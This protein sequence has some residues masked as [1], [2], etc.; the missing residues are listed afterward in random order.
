MC[1]F[2]V[3]RLS[4][5]T[6]R[7]FFNWFSSSFSPLVYNVMLVKIFFCGG[8]NVTKFDLE[9]F[10]VNFLAINHSDTLINS[11]FNVISTFFKLFV[12]VENTCVIC[13]QVKL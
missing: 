11:L 7:Y 2:H 3:K 1:C 10:E 5:N 8:R 4:I 6:R 12:R 9:T 13:K